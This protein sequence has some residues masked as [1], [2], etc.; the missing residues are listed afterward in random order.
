MIVLLKSD[1]NVNDKDN[2]GMTALMFAAAWGT[3]EIVDILI[4]AGANVNAQDNDDWTAFDH[5]Q[6]NEHLQA[7]DTLKLLESLTQI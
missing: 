6:T 3:P 2:N 7:S 5:A 1:A 4:K